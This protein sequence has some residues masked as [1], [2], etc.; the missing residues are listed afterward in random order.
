MARE[1]DAPV[2]PFGAT[3]SGVTGL[4]PEARLIAG[5]GPIPAG[6]YGVTEG[7]VDAWVDELTGVVAMTLDGWQRL[8]DEPIEP[9]VTSD[10][11]QLLEYARTVIHNGA[12][13][14]L[15][16]ARHPERASVNDTSYAAVLWS[17]YTDGLDRLSAWLIRRLTDPRYVDDVPLAEASSGLDYAFPLPL[18]GDGLRF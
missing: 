5:D 12:G 18:F 15:E 13:S 3:R 4:V 14:Y 1:A 17:R 9:E 8:S 11:E 10:R 7:Q 2:A 16:A 6:S